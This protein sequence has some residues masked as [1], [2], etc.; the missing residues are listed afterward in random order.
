MRAGQPSEEGTVIAQPTPTI[1]NV[2]PKQGNRRQR[3][4]IDVINTRL[5]RR[6]RSLAET[7]AP[8]KINIGKDGKPEVRIDL[9]AM[10]K[11]KLAAIGAEIEHQHELTANSDPT[12]DVCSKSIYEHGEL[13]SHRVLAPGEDFAE[14]P[15]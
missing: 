10:K 6:I 15:E 12:P 14:E 5:N 2:Q 13:V 11:A 7:G 8:L 3:R 4:R 1:A 9:R